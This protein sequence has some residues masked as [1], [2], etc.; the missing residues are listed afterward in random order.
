MLA[1]QY[2]AQ[3]D[4]EVRDAVLGIVGTVITFRVG[5]ADTEV[6]GKEFYPEI[7]EIDLMNLPNYH[8]YLKLLIDG[9]VS[10]PFSA[11]TLMPAD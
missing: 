7:T 4:L 1:H 9:V 2:L 10:Q 11:E 8:I 5:P 6:L 3:L